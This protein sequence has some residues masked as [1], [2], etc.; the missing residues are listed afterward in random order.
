MN[1]EFIWDSIPDRIRKG[2]FLPVGRIQPGPYSG[3]DSEEL[4]NKNLLT[5]P[6]DWYYRDNSID[7]TLNKHGY[8]TVEFDTV[9]WAN[10]IVVF[11]CSNVF[12]T[13][14]HVEDTL[15]NQLSTLTNTPVINMGVGASSIEYSSYNSMILSKHYP[16]PKAVVHV[17]SSIDRTSYYNHKNVTHHGSWTSNDTGY[18]SHWCEVA[19]HA[20]T[21]ALMMQL[22]N[23][24][25]WAKKT[26]YYETSFFPDTV[27]SLK[28]HAID[29][30]DFARDL[31]H[32]GRESQHKLAQQIKDK[33]EL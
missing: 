1:Y 18:F 4:F 8:R 10:S 6:V 16:I 14:L 12:G 32:P 30:C 25:I 3:T 19:S 9:D 21:H 31:A 24:E 20:K 22:I 23:Q 28:L 15:A 29:R 2:T 11:G 27:V 33:L 7:Y 5:Q 17:Y 13:G 26:K